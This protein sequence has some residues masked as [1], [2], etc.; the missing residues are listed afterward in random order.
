[1][2]DGLGGIPEGVLENKQMYF[3]KR[4]LIRRK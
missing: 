3:W 2:G 1:L 4:L